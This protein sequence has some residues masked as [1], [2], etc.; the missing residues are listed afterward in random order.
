MHTEKTI[1][2]KR[3]GVKDIIFPS[4]NRNDWDELP[5]YIREGINGMPVDNY[6]QIFEI[7]F[8]SAKENKS[9]ESKGKVV[10]A[11]GVTMEQVLGG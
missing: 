5:D 11:A 2:A 10:D 4:S 3:S 9:E 8:A 1:A 7:V 6:E